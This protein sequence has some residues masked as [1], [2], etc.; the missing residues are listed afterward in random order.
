MSPNFT[1]PTYKPWQR[2]QLPACYGCLSVALY[3]FYSRVNNKRKC[4]L[5][6]FLFFFAS[7]N[8]EGHQHPSTI[9]LQRFGLTHKNVLPDHK[10]N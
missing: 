3:S 10:L 9:H 1:A 4:R 8:S 2:T 6:F 5:L 7:K